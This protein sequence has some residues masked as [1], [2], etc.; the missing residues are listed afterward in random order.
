[1]PEDARHAARMTAAPPIRPRPLAGVPGLSLLLAG[2]FALFMFAWLVYTELVAPP[3]VLA[4]HDGPASPLV[5]WY[6]NHWH[7][8]TAD[9]LLGQWYVVAR[10]FTAFF[11]VGGVG[12]LVLLHRPVRPTPR[13]REPRRMA[14]AS[15]LLIGLL[16]GLSLIGP[17]PDLWPLLTAAV[18]TD[19]YPKPHPTT[20][21]EWDLLVVGKDGERRV[22]EPHQLWGQGRAF[23]ARY[24][25]AEAARPDQ[26]KIDQYRR[27]LLGV[28]RTAFPDLDVAAIEVWRSEWDVEAMALPPAD[29]D[30]PRVHERLAVVWADGGAS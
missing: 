11:L 3:L 20:N 12:L 8:D 26:P 25:F 23:E 15:W 14:L 2:G 16:A 10:L 13:V 5:A 1:M 29:H 4:G 22:L 21:Q 17:R 24:L 9:E 27:Y 18:Y 7:Y 6:A 28:A 19:I 30:R